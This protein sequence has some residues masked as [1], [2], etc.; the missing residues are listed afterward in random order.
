MCSTSP[1]QELYSQSYQQVG[2]TFASITNFHEFYTELDLNNQGVECLRLLNEIIADFDELLGG[3]GSGDGGGGASDRFRAI[4]KIKTIGSTY[5]AAVGLIPEF[6][7]APESED[8]GISA[9]TYLAQL[10]EFVFAMRDRLRNIN[11]NSY[12]NFTLRVG[13]NVGPVVAGVIGARKP[14]YDI[15]GNTVNVA[16]RMDSTGV[17]NHT[18]VKLIPN[19]FTKTTTYCCCPLCYAVHGGSVRDS[20]R[21]RLRVPVPRQGQG[22]GQGGDDDISAGGEEGACNN[23]DG[24]PHPGVRGRSR[25]A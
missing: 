18:Q 12:N 4:D 19:Y 15:W 3:D 9:V 8:G 14:Q 16:S 6:R 10:A 17:P 5:M 7:I 1:S 21:A 24:R 25:G 11:E 22:E 23:Q 13:L 2:V 20:A